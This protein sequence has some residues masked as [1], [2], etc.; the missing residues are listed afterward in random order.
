MHNLI[1]KINYKKNL[2]LIIGLLFCAPIWSSNECFLVQENQTV[3]KEEGRGCSK[4]YAP[5]STFKIA[6]SLMG[7]DSGLL[8]DES[9]PEWP[10]KKE[11]ELYLNVWKYPH[12]PRTW[13]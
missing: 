5:E 10:Y 2:L 1:T 7:F 8:E 11:Y 12:N 6:L 9:H 3:L 4:P 13:I